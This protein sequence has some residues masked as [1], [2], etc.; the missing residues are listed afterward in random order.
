MAENKT[1]ALDVCWLP[2]PEPFERIMSALAKLPQEGALQVHIHRQ[3]YPLYEE[4]RERGYAWQTSPLPDG[5]FSI[6]IKRNA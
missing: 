2:P 6:R 1:Q 4:L 5:T 3:P